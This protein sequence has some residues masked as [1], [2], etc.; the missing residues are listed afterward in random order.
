MRPRSSSARSTTYSTQ[1]SHPPGT[2]IRAHGRDRASLRDS[3]SRLRCRRRRPTSPR[4][5]SLS[6]CATATHPSPPR[7]CAPSPPPAR[8]ASRSRPGLPPPRLRRHRS[9]PRRSRSR[10]TPGQSPVPWFRRRRRRCMSRPYVL[11]R[12]PHP[13]VSC[14]R[15]MVSCC[16][17]HGACRGT[18]ALRE[19]VRRP[20]VR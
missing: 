14:R 17:R 8:A 9:S 1:G 6:R 2:R 12:L 20:C 13:T 15:G 7:S 11:R 4:R 10:R 19:T 16:N 3:R 18:H 5:R